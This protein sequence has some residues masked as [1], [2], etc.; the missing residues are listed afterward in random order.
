MREAALRVVAV[1]VGEVWAVA[2]AVEPG[3]EGLGAEATAAGWLGVARTGKGTEAAEVAE[4]GMLASMVTRAPAEGKAVD[5][6]GPA[7]EWLRV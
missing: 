2:M 6:L 5:S 3:A 1:R 4:A 7:A